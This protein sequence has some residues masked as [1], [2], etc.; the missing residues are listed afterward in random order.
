M[1]KGKQHMEKGF[2]CKRKRVV[3]IKSDKFVPE[4]GL[5]V[6]ARRFNREKEFFII[7]SGADPTG[8]LADVADHYR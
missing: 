1:D 4:E 5:M 8:R 6:D 2:Q 7:K 3:S